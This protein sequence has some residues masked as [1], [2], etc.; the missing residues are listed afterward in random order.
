MPA[1][2]GGHLTSFGGLQLWACPPII[3]DQLVTNDDAVEPRPRLLPTPTL[4][5]ARC[6]SFQI[7]LGFR[8]GELVPTV[9][10]S[11]RG[12]GLELATA[13]ASS[14]EGFQHRFNRLTVTDLDT[15][16]HQLG[17]VVEYRSTT[18]LVAICVGRFVE[19]VV[20]EVVLEPFSALVAGSEVFV[21]HRHTLLFFPGSFRA[22]SLSKPSC[23]GGIG[24]LPRFRAFGPY[25]L[26]LCPF[27]R[28]R[29]PRSRQARSE[30]GGHFLTPR[31]NDKVRVLI[32]SITVLP[33]REG[34]DGSQMR[35]MRQGMGAG[36]DQPG[37]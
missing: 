16:R 9:R 26:C 3:T 36:Y 21:P 30:R 20:D 10:T 24:P 37:T 15:L 8:R 27:L 13:I 19:A 34:P 18:A 7:P 11:R 22:G 1:R 14:E 35:A 25:R 33:R 17:V 2:K 29:S 32:S 6:G 4:P 28:C 12:T 31:S 5:G 23:R